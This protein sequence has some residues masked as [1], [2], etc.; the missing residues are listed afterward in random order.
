MMEMCIRDSHDGVGGRARRRPV[1]AARHPDR[2]EPAPVAPRY[3][4]AGRVAHHPA[5]E[6]HATAPGRLL[7]DR[8][9][10]LLRADLRRDADRVDLGSEAGDVQLQ[11]LGGLA[12]RHDADLPAGG[13][14]AP[15][16]VDRLV[17]DAEM[18]RVVDEVARDQIVHRGGDRKRASHGPE[19]LGAG[20]EAVHVEHLELSLIHI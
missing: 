8:L 6:G 16:R 11:S 4:G 7:E 2:H 1:P 15:E 13:P 5:G 12:I 3:V 20:S 10:G 9:V 19:E 18:A 14:Q 17:G